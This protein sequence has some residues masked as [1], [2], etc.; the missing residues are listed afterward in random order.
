MLLASA[1]DVDDRRADRRGRV[2]VVVAVVAVAAHEGA[3]RVPRAGQRAHQADSPR[4]SPTST[5]RCSR[6]PRAR[7]SAAWRSSSSPAASPRCSRASS[8]TRSPPASTCSPSASRSGSAPGSRR[9]TS[10]PWCRCGCTRWPSPPATRSCSSPPSATP[11]PRSSWP[12]C[13]PRPGCPTA[14]STWCT[15]TR[16]PSTRC[17]TTPDVAAVSFVGST[18]IAKYIYET[19]LAHGKRVQALGGA[20]NHAI[21]LP[22]AGIDYAS[23]HLVAAAFGSAG[24]RCMAISA[25]VAVGGAADELVAA[26]SEKARATKVGPGR[27]ADSEMGPVITAAARDRIVGLIGT[28]AEQGADLAVDGRG[29]TVAGHEN[30]FFVGP[31]VIDRVTHRDGRLP[32]GDLR[33]GAVGGPHGHRRRRHQ[34]DQLQ[35]VRQRH[36]DLHRLRRGGAHVP[37]RGERRHDRHQRAGP[38][39]DG[40]LLLRRLEGLAVRPEPHPRPR[41]RA[42][43]HPRQGRHPALAARRGR[44]AALRFHFPTST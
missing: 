24:E 21:V 5:A 29:L 32:R 20:K 23:D 7:C 22:D 3:V 26:V 38:G 15:A 27:D 36:R 6:T 19:G 43:L 41:G 17:S 37:A 16:R 2:R 44:V 4:S 10:R 18:P 30:G 11:R 31:T 13:G 25:A 33:P 39:A 9:S 12:S 8:P 34:A 1:A 40:L 42:V 28:G 14:C 35:P